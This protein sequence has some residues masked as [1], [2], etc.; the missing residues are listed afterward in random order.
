MKK[1][2]LLLLVPLTLL[3]QGCAILMASGLPTARSPEHLTPGKTQ[4]AIDLFYGCPIAAGYS[5]DGLEYIEQI[6]FIDGC[7]IGWKVAR[8]CI[9]SVL[10]AC[11]YFLWEIPGFIIE[12][13]NFYYPEH[14]YFL[15]YNAN[16]ELVRAIPL[17]SPE[18]QTLANLP[19]ASESVNLRAMKGINRTPTPQRIA[20]GL[21]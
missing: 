16:N 5:D 6:Q 7:P 8:I 15:V 18:G 14:T 17:H 3:F 20:P 12:A 19:W 1:R 13:S 11:T 9:H 10:D 21:R 2:L 4:A